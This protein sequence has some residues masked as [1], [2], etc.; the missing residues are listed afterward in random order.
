MNM[1]QFR[2]LPLMGILRGITEDIVEP[3]TEAIISS[4]LRTVEIT[5]N[6]MDAPAL[7]ELMSKVAGNRL[8]I[9]AG[10]VL[11]NDDLQSALNAGA[12][13][14][15]LPTLVTDVVRSCVSN[16]IPVFP[17]ALTPQEISNVWSEGPTMVKV[18]PAGFFGPTYFREIKG[19]FPDIQLLACGG[20]NTENI[21][22]FFSYGATAVAFGASVFKEEWLA[23]RDFESI[24]LSIEKLVDVYQSIG[25]KR[26]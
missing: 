8:T 4:G 2:R 19:P 9:G 3:L 5:M 24:S 21:Q 22:S 13:F 14:I 15:V 18:F 6:T 11:T 17:G 16:G 20:V 7:I 10:T 25:T 1:N 23:K 12:T 26:K